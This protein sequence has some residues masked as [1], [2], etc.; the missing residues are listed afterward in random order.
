M[1]DQVIDIEPD[2]SFGRKPRPPFG[3]IGFV[4]VLLVVIAGGRSIALAVLDF[5]WFAEIGQTATWWKQAY[6][7]TAPVFYAAIAAFAAARGRRKVR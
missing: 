4:V 2:G 6:I 5:A 1:N 3:I 7:R